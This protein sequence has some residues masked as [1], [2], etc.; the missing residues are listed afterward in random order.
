MGEFV[1]R[2]GA[3][4]S[5]G[6]APVAAASSFIP[7]AG[8]VL[9]GVSTVA[10]LYGTYLAAQQADENLKLARQA[11]QEQQSRTAELDAENRRQQAIGNV[12]NYGDYAQNMMKNTQDTYGA[13]NRQIGR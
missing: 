4:M 7:G 9:N 2:D 5:S 13:Y 12:I 8:L 11:Y 6:G 3:P 10:S 1:W